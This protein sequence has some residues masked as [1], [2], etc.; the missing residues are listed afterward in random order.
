MGFGDSYLWV[1]QMFCRIKIACRYAAVQIE[2]ARF[3]GGVNSRYWLRPHRKIISGSSSGGG[4]N[5]LEGQT[6]M[7]LG[8]DDLD[9]GASWAGFFLIVE[10]SSGGEPL[11]AYDKGEKTSTI[12]EHRISGDTKTKSE[13]VFG[14]QTQTRFPGRSCARLRCVFF[15]VD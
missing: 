11:G 5:H 1:L 7:Y 13:F 10:S 12:P 6:W 8:Q 9:G 4:K 15:P 14:K 3:R 2:A